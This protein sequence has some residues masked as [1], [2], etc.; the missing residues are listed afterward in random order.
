MMYK[1]DHKQL[2]N[3]NKNDPT[4]DKLTKRI[5]TISPQDWFRAL[6]PDIAIKSIEGLPNNFVA[7][8]KNE[9][10]T[11]FTRL[12]NKNTVFHWEPMNFKELAFPFRML[13]YRADIWEYYAN[14]AGF[15]YDKIKFIHQVA[16]LMDPSCDNGLSKIEDN[17]SSFCGISFYY[18]V[19]KVWEL[20]PKDIVARKLE[21][22]YPLLP[23][24]KNEAG[25]SKPE[26]LRNAISAIKSVNDK[27]LQK[28]FLT[29]MC[30]LA[31]DKN[32]FSVDL[33]RSCI[34]EEE[35]MSSELLE[36]LTK[37]IV[38]RETK[39]AS[40]KASKKASDKTKLLLFK[41]QN[42][43]LSI[44]DIAKTVGVS[45]DDVRVAKAEWLLQ[46]EKLT[47]DIASATGLSATKIKSIHIE[48]LLKFGISHE[49]IAEITK[50]SLKKIAKMQTNLKD[51]D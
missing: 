38:D 50:T 8:I 44:P 18:H 45:E 48:M 37:E 27:S 51:Q 43:S 22:L 9:S 49:E 46:S 1:G 29:I 32:R 21:G 42:D 3:T 31:Q 10:I 33:V 16:I 6:H 23:L 20:D 30:L 39:K 25:V 15:T 28:E 11:D 47:P 2:S 12:I 40:E 14:E 24:M 35:L 4:A 17:S 36:M 19:F 5:F 26:I 7:K 13:R 34:N 41:V